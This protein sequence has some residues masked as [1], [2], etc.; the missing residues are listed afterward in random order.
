MVPPLLR[1]LKASAIVE[2]E[3]V[4]AGCIPDSSSTPSHDRL[5][6]AARSKD[7]WLLNLHPTETSTTPRSTALLNAYVRIAQ[8]DQSGAAR[9]L[10]AD[11]LRLDSGK[12]IHMDRS[13]IARF[14]R[15][16]YVKFNA[17]KPAAPYFELTEM[18][19]S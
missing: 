6:E 12:S 17:E 10:F 14:L 11:G 5:L 9:P 4:R 16:G 18:E 1:P 8:G 15:D 19:S 13:V 3:L 7:W 2:E